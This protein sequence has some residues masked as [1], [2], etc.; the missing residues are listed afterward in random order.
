MWVYLHLDD[1]NPGKDPGSSAF[2][3]AGR[4]FKYVA[5]LVNRLHI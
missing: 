2:S 1:S 5:V 4:A 3:P